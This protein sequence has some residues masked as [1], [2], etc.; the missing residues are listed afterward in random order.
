MS[1]SEDR[2]SGL[3]Q[4][5]SRPSTIT[6]LFRSATSVIETL[7][8]LAVI[9]AVLLNFANI[10]GRYLLGNAIV[11]AD[12][13]LIYL[14]IGIVFVGIIIVTA[15]DAHLR[16][17]M[18]ADLAPD[19]FRRWMR[20]LE[21]LILALVA[22]FVSW[23]ATSISLQLQGFGQRSLSANI[24]MWLPHG[25]AALGLAATAAIAVWI[26]LRSNNDDNSGD[27]T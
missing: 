5:A 19:Q 1:S 13:T 16:M 24:P 18:M 6:R 25:I 2:R 20:R 8:G 17:S 9:A 14:M 11:G 15:R 23:I 7:L 12:E 26:C 27:D 10:V 21:W 3:Q 22:G 4:E